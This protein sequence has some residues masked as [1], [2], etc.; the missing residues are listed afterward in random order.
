[1][2]TLADSGLLVDIS[3]LISEEQLADFDESALDFYRLGEGLYGLPVY[4]SVQCL[5]G[6]KA[7]LEEAGGR[8]ASSAR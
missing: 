5:G 7:M 3:E 8:S 1:M 2:G 6:N 4:I